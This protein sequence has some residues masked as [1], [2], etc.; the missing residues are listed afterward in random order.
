M[1]DGKN[2]N[3]IVGERVKQVRKRYK[4]TQNQ[5]AEDL[6][7][8]GLTPDKVIRAIEHGDRGLTNEKLQ[9]IVDKYG[10]SADYLLLRSDYMTRKEAVQALIG[11]MQNLDVLWTEFIKHIASRSGYEMKECENGHQADNETLVIDTEAPYM[12]FKN[13]SDS[14]SFTIRDTNTFIDDISRYAELRLQMMLERKK[15]D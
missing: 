10:V 1:D 5:L 15:G 9:I 6:G 2:R 13:E 8:K 4:I 7:Y 14:Y 3:K 11:Q 12:K